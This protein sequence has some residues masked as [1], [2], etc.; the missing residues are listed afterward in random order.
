M[1]TRTP[2]HVLKKIEDFVRQAVE[3][4]FGDEFVFDPILVVAHEDPFGDERVHMYVVYDGDPAKLDPDWAV[5][6]ISMVI[7]HMTEEDLPTMPLKRF[8]HKSEWEKFYYYNV[9]PWIPATS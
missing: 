4:R 9:E 6:L 1:V 8:I 2:K 7:D 5:R 3:E